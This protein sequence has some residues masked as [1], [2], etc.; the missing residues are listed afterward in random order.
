MANSVPAVYAQ[1]ALR[2]A[3]RPPAELRALLAELDLPA[4]LLGRAP[5]SGEL[6]AGQFGR[7]FM[8]LVRLSQ[9]D[10]HADPAAAERVKGL[11]T[12]RLMFGWMLQAATLGEALERAAQF[13]LRF[14]E[15]GR[16]FTLVG[17]NPVEWRFP[18]RDDGNE[19]IGIEHF[20]MGRLDWLPGLPG[21]ISALYMWHRLASWMTGCFIDLDA[22]HIDLPRRGNAGRYAVPFRAPVYFRRPHCALL[23]QPRF[24]ELPVVRREPELNRMLA[25]FPAELIRADE[26][27]ASVQARVRAL[28]GED[29]RRELPGLEEVAKRLHM[30]SATLH[31]RLQAEGTSFQKVKDACRRDQ[32]LALLR[33]GRLTGEEIA[34]RLGFSDASGF[35]RAF[36]K[37][38]GRTPMEFRDAEAP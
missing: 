30:A 15:A 27:A 10:L 7:L 23:L 36:R 26:M 29:L 2:L 12:Y 8:G 18:F 1:A 19:R 37:W 33:A 5:A 32:A 9:Q 24:L 25:S 11:S 6:D 31:R 22:V 20:G 38:T 17:R 28:L 21:R 35:V 4:T 16:S 3:R 34:E 14:D 13:F